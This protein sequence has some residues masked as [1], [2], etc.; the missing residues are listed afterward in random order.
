MRLAA[1]FVLAH[2]VICDKIEPITYRGNAESVQCTPCSVSL[3]ASSL[4][5]LVFHSELRIWLFSSSI[6]LFLSYQ[7]D[8]TTL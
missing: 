6:D 1:A 5:H 3:L 8:S 2:S 7:T 4:T